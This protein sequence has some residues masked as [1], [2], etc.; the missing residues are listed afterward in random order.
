L[1]IKQLLDE[2]AAGHKVIGS[3]CVFVPE[4][5][6]R[7]ADATIVGLCTGADFATEEV[8]KLLPETPVT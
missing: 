3:F 1:R 6:V 5:I 2:K 4:E 8:E 7:A